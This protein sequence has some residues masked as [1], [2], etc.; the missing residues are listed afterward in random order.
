MN[1]DTVVSGFLLYCNMRSQVRVPSQAPDNK[2][3]EYR[4]YADKYPQKEQIDSFEDENELKK[5]LDEYFSEVFPEEFFEFA[6]N[7]I[8]SLKLPE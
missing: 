2:P 6:S 3:P 8:K 4:I 7:L 1:P 5:Y